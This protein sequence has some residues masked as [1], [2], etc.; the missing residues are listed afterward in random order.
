MPSDRALLSC[1]YTATGLF[2]LNCVLTV[3]ALPLA[4][5]KTVVL[6]SIRLAFATALLH[7]RPLT[8]PLGH[9]TPA[10]QPATTASMPQT[11]R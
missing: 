8:Q 3:V 6:A 2:R 4:S 9:G 7:V 1:S 5:R 10:V 11:R